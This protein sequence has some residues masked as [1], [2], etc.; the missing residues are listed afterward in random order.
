MKRSPGAS[1]SAPSNSRLSSLRDGIETDN[2][3]IRRLENKLGFKK[4]KNASARCFEDFG[5]GDVWSIIEKVEPK[6]EVKRQKAEPKTEVK[7]KKEWISEDDSDNQMTDDDG[8]DSADE[9][10]DS[11]N[12][13]GD[14]D[15]SDEEQSTELKEDIYGRLR[16]REGNIIKA[17]SK[18]KN[19]QESEPSVEDEIDEKAMKRIRGLLNRLSASN[20]QTISSSVEDVLKDYSLFQVT[21]CLCKC[22]NDQLLQDSFLSPQR[23]IGEY[24]MLISVLNT[25]I[26]DEIGGHVVHQF[27]KKFDSV[28]TKLTDSK[29]DEESK[30]M[31][32]LVSFISYLHACGMIDSNL[33]FDI[34]DKLVNRFN[35]KCIQVILLQLRMIGFVLRRSDPSR[36]KKMIENIQSQ[37]VKYETT[38]KRISFMLEALSAIKNNNIIKLNS[39]NEDSPICSVDINSLRATIKNG[40]RTKTK[41]SYIPGKFEEV[42]QNNRWWING[43]LTLKESKTETKEPSSEEIKI[44]EPKTV[45]SDI[46]EKLCA[47]LRLVTPLRKAILKS[48]ITCEDY[49]ECTQRLIKVGGKNFIEVMNVCL[50]VALKEKK[51]NPF[52]IYLFKQLSSG[53]R[54]YKMAL[55][56][57]LKDRLNEPERLSKIEKSNMC[58]YIVELLKLDVIPITVLKNFQFNDLSEESVDLLKSILI[59]VFTSDEPIITKILSKLKPKDPFTVALKL[60]ISCFMDPQYK[61]KMLFL[62]K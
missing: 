23:L 41:V 34:I 16:D 37:A 33:I 25:N 31:D 32:N 10:D 39:L 17:E 12:S 18:E 1:L 47:K 24:A 55:I 62:K 9:I 35:R 53:D 20:L 48:L 45:E 11:N 50:L 19:D 2:E 8:L 13:D 5:L 22:I 54:K 36:L 61:E 29:E 59:P 43:G 7:R 56:Y 26:G 21:Q 42:I 49:I 27:V 58:K 3:I 38:D 14:D 51:F 60:F 6:P 30:L 52:Y 44:S 57:S 4:R 40:L 28:M 15:I 46:G